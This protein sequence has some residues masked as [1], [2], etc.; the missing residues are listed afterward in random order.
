MQIKA[1]CL[2]SLHSLAKCC[3]HSNTWIQNM[4][5]GWGGYVTWKQQLFVGFW[6]KVKSVMP[7]PSSPHNSGINCL[8]DDPRLLL[9]FQN[10]LLF[11]KVNKLASTFYVI[12]TSLS[13]K[14]LSSKLQLRHINVVLLP[15]QWTA[16]NK[17]KVPHYTKYMN[18]IVAMH[19]ASS[20]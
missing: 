15:T 16:H 4:T 18:G 13:L 12:S 19:G 9:A 2:S 20:Y 5:S 11:T 1:G 10:L 17:I 6:L 14:Y 8:H 7:F 3:S